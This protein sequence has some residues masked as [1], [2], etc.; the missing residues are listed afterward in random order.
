MTVP[1]ERA[2]ANLRPNRFAW[3]GPEDRCK[4]CGSPRVRGTA[5]CFRHGGA[6]VT[7]ARARE[8]LS[9]PRIGPKRKA[10]ALRHIE[11]AARNRDR[12][13]RRE[14]DGEAKAVRAE[15]AEVMQAVRTLIEAGSMTRAFMERARQVAL[16]LRPYREPW[17]A[18]AAALYAQGVGDGGRMGAF[19]A[20]CSTLGLDGAEREK[21][22]AGLGAVA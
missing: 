2:L 3:M 1:T 18:L 6:R 4:H 13:H 7:L 12:A 20:F 21:A 8:D 9:N 15:C 10:K 16:S 5:V 11:R 22:R 14:K 17:A 19:M